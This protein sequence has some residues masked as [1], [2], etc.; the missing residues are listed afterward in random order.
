MIVDGSNVLTG[1]LNWSATSE[2]KTLE[3]LIVLNRPAINGSYTQRFE[4]IWNYGKGQFPAVLASVSKA[5]EELVSFQPISVV[6]SKIEELTK[7]LK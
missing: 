5:D 7:A 1:S 4:M 3:N 2:L 6:G